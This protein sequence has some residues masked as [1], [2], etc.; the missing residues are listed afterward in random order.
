[1]KIVLSTLNAKYIHSSL[2]LRYLKAYSQNEFPD[3]E[4]IEYSIKEP[5]LN[6]LSDLYKKNPDIVGFSCYIWNIE[7]TLELVKLI[8]KVMPNVSIVLGGP[9]V[10]YD[11]KYWLERVKEIDY[12]VYGEGEET[13]L[14]LLKALKEN[15]NISKINGLAY[16]IENNFV[17]TPPQK[18]LNLNNIP[19]PYQDENDIASLKDKIVYFEASRGCPFSCAYCLSSAD[20]GVLFFELE[21]VKE[22][23]LKLIK[24]EVK[25]IKFVD[26]TFNINRKFAI[27]I[28]KFL[29]ENNISTVFQFEITADIMHRDVLQFLVENAP[30]N[31]FRFEIGIQSTNEY[32]NSLINRRQ[33]FKK[34]SN[35]VLKLKENK[36]IDLHLDLIAGLPEEDY[37]SFRKT[38]N[39]VFALRPEELQLGFL[40]ILRGTQMWREAS[41][42]NYVYMEKAPY[43]IFQNSVL[44]FADVIRIKS[45]EDVL[46][47]YWNSNRMNYTV[48]YLI[49]HEFETPFDFFQEFGQFW[50]AN[51]WNRIGHQIET[52]FERLHQFLKVKTTL[53]IDFVE[54]LM[55]LDYFLNHNYKPR[56]TWW[57]FNISKQQQI[58]YL[59][60]LVAKPDLVTDN[61]VNLNLDDRTIHKHIMIETSRFDI[62]SYLQDGKIIERDTLMIVYYNPPEK[63]KLFFKTK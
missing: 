21:R 10:S 59:Q 13:F 41:K 36:K 46:E 53:N 6:L 61:F 20:T 39:D 22:E 28:F 16:N 48:E 49:T 38:F 55:K 2:A 33:N 30:A 35:T 56:K 14:Q 32:T 63:P 18:K 3:I 8:K 40:K 60:E 45:L 37:A 50:D 34:L 62:Y 7:E 47:K 11:I 58:E 24:S 44:S 17:M 25:T 5:I 52:L 12:I 19:S 54:A 26:R 57:E 31:Y 4:I 29:I 15:R 9:E 27:E 51:G 1:M 23:L 42:Y 43:E